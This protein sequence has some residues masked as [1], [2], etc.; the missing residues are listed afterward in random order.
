[1]DCSTQSWNRPVATLRSLLPLR[2]TA[3]RAGN[4]RGHFKGQ[5]PLVQITELAQLPDDLF[6]ESEWGL[7]QLDLSFPERGIMINDLDATIRLNQDSL[8]I[9]AM[10]GQARKHRFKLSGL[11][12][13]Y[14]PYLRGDKKPVEAN[15]EIQ[16]P[17][18]YPS[19]L[20][21]GATA[22]SFN[23]R[24][25]VQSLQ[26]LIE[27]VHGRLQ[28]RIDSV[29][30]PHYPLNDL[31]LTA[32]LNHQCLTNP[33]E[34]P[35]VE[36]EHLQGQLKGS[37]PIETAFKIYD[38]SAPQIRLKAKTRMDFA[39]LDGLVP[40]KYFKTD[41]GIMKLQ[42]NYFN[43]FPEE[44]TVENTLLSA[45]ITG[46]VDLYDAALTY[47][48]RDF[49]FEDIAGHLEFNNNRLS[50][51][52][53]QLVVNGNR[54]RLEGSVYEYLP[55][56]FQE[57]QDF[58]LQLSLNVPSLDF[59]KFST[60]RN[61]L[62]AEKIQDEYLPDSEDNDAIDRLLSQANLSLFTTIDTVQYGNF[63][64]RNVIGEAH[65]GDDRVLLDSI[66]MRMANG[67]FDMHGTI[68]DIGLHRPKLDMR[69]NFDNINAERFFHS[70]HNFGQDILTSDN[71]RGIIQ[72]DISFKA[73]LDDH[74][75]VQPETMDGDINLSLQRGQLLDFIG[76]K[77]LTGF[78]FRRRQLDDIF[79]DTLQTRLYVDGLDL[80]FDYFELNSTAASFGIEGLYSFSADDRTHMT[81]E[82]PLGNLFNR[83]I[84]RKLVLESKKKRK[85]LPIIVE[86]IEENNQIQFKVRL[87]RNKFD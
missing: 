28:I 39:Q 86:A 14:R 71:I 78:L 69:F 48:Y 45:T 79:F 8:W 74:Y 33:K 37:I 54:M 3:M 76:L 83:H 32:K 19:Q 55:F 12:R 4:M 61:V 9:D 42:L 82:I 41:A 52:F 11:L 72:S 81:L 6:Y 65:V 49:R 53:P 22:G 13:D 24:A 44:L 2:G 15:L 59:S 51:A 23:P 20:S 63:I 85:G 46:Q 84:D 43:Y 16:L 73:S 1:R 30:A 57:Q 60:P 35:C 56:F 29:H 5:F 68:D 64:G 58:N 75:S 36:V 34:F 50:L 62:V 80:S 67:Q 17:Q 87:L 31:Y 21:S 77:N 38:L 66:S 27:L 70:F 40:S 26:R 10:N 7:A 25:S 47:L 18:F